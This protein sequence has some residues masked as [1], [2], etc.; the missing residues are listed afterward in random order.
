MRKIFVNKKTGFIVK[1]LYSP[2][3]IRDYRGVLFYSTEPLIPKV[4]YFNLPGLG[5]YYIDQGNFTVAKEPR[6][7]RLAKIPTPQ[8][9]IKP[10]TDFKIIFGNNPN[11]CTIFWDKKL[12]VFDNDFKEKPL[13]MLYFILYHEYGHSLFKSEHY[14]DLV[15]S[16][17]MKKKGFNISQIQ[18]ASLESLSFRQG[19]RKQFLTEQLIKYNKNVQ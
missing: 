10:P 17:L 5:E 4:K 12:I 8:R 13:Y 2:I 19:A 14:A 3:I 15:A 18:A 7:H 16:N 9:R 11:K 6:K 1:D